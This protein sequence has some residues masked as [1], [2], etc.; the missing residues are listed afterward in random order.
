M[1]PGP[2]PPLV[3][4]CSHTPQATAPFTPW[5]TIVLHS[6]AMRDGDREA[7]GCAALAHG[8]ARTVGCSAAGSGV[9]ILS[10][11]SVLTTSQVSPVLQTVAWPNTTCGT[12]AQECWMCAG[13]GCIFVFTRVRALMSLGL[14]C[15]CDRARIRTLRGDRSHVAS[16]SLLSKASARNLEQVCEATDLFI[17][18]ANDGRPS[19]NNTTGGGIDSLWGA[20][21]E[22][23]P[24][25]A[26][27]ADLDA[28]FQDAPR[29]SPRGQPTPLVQRHVVSAAETGK[30]GTVTPWGAPRWRMALPGRPCTSRATTS[31]LAYH[32]SGTTADGRRTCAGE[33]YVFAFTRILELM[34]SGLHCEI[35][36]RQEPIL[37]AVPT[38]SPFV[39][40]VMCAAENT[41]ASTCCPRRRHA[42]EG[43]H[44]GGRDAQALR[45]TIR[46]VR[47]GHAGR[48]RRLPFLAGVQRRHPRVQR[49]SRPTILPRALHGHRAV[50]SGLPPSKMRRTVHP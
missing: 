14:Y 37:G 39:Y 41:Q 36:S 42:G 47:L 50:A 23:R 11:S 3:V 35:P 13:E 30:S 31:R 32:E 12:V 1:S 34:S 38:A 6:G 21:L 18:S 8:V 46:Y 22:T 5:K 10:S 40:R 16:S 19:G 48:A 15:T 25:G 44:G 45:I 27:T 4:V 29:K 28:H 49:A 26:D 33:G 20:V 17:S 24:C 2:S 43:E 9:F 7:I